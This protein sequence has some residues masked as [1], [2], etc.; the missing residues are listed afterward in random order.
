MNEKFVVLIHGLWMP[1]IE[2]QLLGN[3]LNHAGF[4]TRQFTY[5]SVRSSPLEN[6]IDLQRFIKDIKAPELHF[7]CHSLGGLIVRHLFNEYPD[8]RPGRIVTL[9]TPHSASSSAKTL[10]KIFAGR[11]LLG[12]STEHGLLGAVPAWQSNNELGV[13]A[14]T[15]RLGLGMIVPGIARP[16]DGSVTVQE[17]M[18]ENMSDHII[19]PVSHFGMLLSKRVAYQTIHFLQNGKFDHQQAGFQEKVS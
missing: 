6:T 15:L 5:K 10:T 7:V 18:L 9:G 13:I 16:N 12:K 2:M 19:L 14:G 17:T 8:Q 4:I 1:G 11:L 3:R